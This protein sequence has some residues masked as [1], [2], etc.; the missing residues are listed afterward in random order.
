MRKLNCILI[1]MILLM[2]TGCSSRKN[3]SHNYIYKGE[4]ELWSVELKVNGTVTFNE[5]NGKAEYDSICDRVFTVT[6]KKDLSK[7]SSV[8]HL[9]ISYKSSAGD[10]KLTEDYNDSPP[11]KRTYTM[12]SGGRGQAIENKD[13]VIKVIINIDGKIQTIDM[14][15]VN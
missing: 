5:K 11:N 12:K 6:Y 7:L 8:K 14:K 1:V 10:S 4:N 3:I 15:N 13:E 2:V 9:E